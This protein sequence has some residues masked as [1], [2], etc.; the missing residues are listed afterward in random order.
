MVGIQALLTAQLRQL[1]NFLSFH[2]FVEML[3]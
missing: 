3:Q 1:W 2:V